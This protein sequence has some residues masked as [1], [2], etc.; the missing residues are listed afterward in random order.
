MPLYNNTSTHYPSC[1]YILEANMILS[2]L[3]PTNVD[4]DLDDFIF[5]PQNNANQLCYQPLTQ[6]Q[7]ILLQT[8]ELLDA[9]QIIL[10]L[11]KCIPKRKLKCIDTLFQ[12][13]SG[14]NRL[15]TNDVSYLEAYWEIKPIEI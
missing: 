2:S 14:T 12:L 6:K 15:Y 9:P 8:L 13:D 11:N 10:T 5:P 4:T 1:D 3:S 7:S